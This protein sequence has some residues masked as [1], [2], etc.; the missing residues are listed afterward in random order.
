MNYTYFSW[1]PKSVVRKNNKKIIII[2]VL[3]RGEDT[4]QEG[5]ISPPKNI[6]NTFSMAIGN[7]ELM[8][9]CLPITCSWKQQEWN[10]GRKLEIT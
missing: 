10:K 1:H 4:V 8:Q 9:K 7:V 3:L 6:K 5:T 2:I